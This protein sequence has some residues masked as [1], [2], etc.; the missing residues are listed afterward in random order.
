ME[1]PFARTNITPVITNVVSLAKI[2]P[3]QPAGNSVSKGAV[4]T[5]EATKI[6]ED[7]VQKPFQ[8][9]WGKTLD[10]ME[11]AMVMKNLN[12]TLLDLYT[13]ALP[14]C[15]VQENHFIDEEV[16]LIK[17]MGDHL[18]NLHRLAGVQ[19]GLGKYLFEG[20]PSAQEGTGASS[21]A[22]FEGSLWHPPGIRDVA[23]ASFYSD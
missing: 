10:T 5:K 16:K 3:A 12:Q 20:S 13:L 23:Q 21:P 2:S 1:L 6:I 11:V 15:D 19:A 14:I 9:E 22:A 8:D 7:D 18:T 4:I 17:K